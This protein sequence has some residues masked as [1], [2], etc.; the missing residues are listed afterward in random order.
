MPMYPPITINKNSKFFVAMCKDTD[1]VHS[2]ICLGVEID[3]KQILLGSFGK[4]LTIDS[5]FFSFLF[6]ETHGR[7]KNERVFF[8]KENNQPISS[9]LTYKAYSLN[10][11]YYLEFL[12]YMRK[13]SCDQTKFSKLM[14]YCPVD[15]TENEVTMKWQPVNTLNANNNL[16]GLSVSLDEHKQI[17]I[18]NTCRH[19]AISLT[20][21]ASHLSDLGQGIS[22]FFMMRAPLET[23]IKGGILGAKS[24]YI[25]ILP[26]PPKSFSGLSEK[27][28]AIITKLYNR[29]D[30]IIL[31]EQDNIFTIKKFKKIK[32]LYESITSNEKSSLPEVL[33]EIS[34]WVDDN[35]KLISTHRKYHWISF[36]T[37]T[38]KL[39]KKI[40]EEKMI[41]PTTESP[42]L[43]NVH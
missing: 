13:I 12:H 22:S 5:S 30:E 19:S 35:K 36:P 31:N 34:D 25:Y 3:N 20:K 11:Q 21:R 33:N 39:F 23:K 4:V 2:Y 26:M 24:E 32:L 9:K 38:E 6:T 43:L 10:Y 28:Y 8:S 42:I 41:P 7:I 1:T 18:L 17:S 27:K 29:L 37:A 14:A 16:K 15:E 40:L